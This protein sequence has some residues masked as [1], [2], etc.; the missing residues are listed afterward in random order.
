MKV[1]K[2]RY[3]TEQGANAQSGSK[4]DDAKGKDSRR[5]GRVQALLVP[6]L[7]IVTA[8]IIGGV[9]VA[10]SDLEVMQLFYHIEKQIVTT[11][12]DPATEISLADAK[13]KHPDEVIPGDIIVIRKARYTVVEEVADPETEMS[14]DE[15]RKMFP[16]LRIGLVIVQGFFDDPKVPLSAAWEAVKLA[17]TALFEGSIGNPKKMYEALST[18][19]DSG[20][21]SL[22]PSA[23]LPF[24][25]SL[26]L[27]TPYILTGLAVALGFQ[28]GLF[29]IG[30]EG[31]FFIGGLT[32]V[33]VGYS[34]QGLPSF[35]HLPLCLLAGIL[36]GG[37]WGAIPGYLKAKTGAHEVINTIMTNYIAFRLSEWLLNGPMKREGYRPVSPE[38]QP[39][40]Y[41]PQLFPSPIR[42]HAGFF[43]ALAVAAFVYWLL[44]KTTIGF[45]IRTVGAN[46]HAARYAG[47]N[48]TKNFVLAMALSGGLAGL[49]GANDILGLIHYM[50]NAFY[51]GYGFDA[52]ALALLGKSHPVGVVLAALL[53]GTLRNGA[54]RM[55]SVAQIPIDIISILQALIII[56]IAA[57]EIIRWLY[58][59]R[60][61]REEGETVF[62]RGWGA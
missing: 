54:T 27:A 12:K 55:Q 57:P 37:L 35:I 50:P 16:E 7:A 30:A 28:C 1:R 32:S 60:V 15:G 46:P 44:F 47:I 41:L 58:R 24:T 23:F 62:T 4:K 18:Y 6:I 40:A 8:L 38:I 39:S 53:F 11:V 19:F 17:Y 3:L 10:V 9:I 26:V 52:I 59:F 51:S 21:A 42:F 48:I 14:L 43:L 33:F 5:R 25:E 31:Q 34:L 2:E 49:A 36:G 56:F 45:E 22:L 29:N 20:D 61:E 13:E